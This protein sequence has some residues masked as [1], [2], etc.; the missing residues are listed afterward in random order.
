MSPEK[1]ARGT[2]VMSRART[3]K[4]P[5]YALGRRVFLLEWRSATYV[6]PDYCPHRGGPL[7]LGTRSEDPCAIRCPW[8]GMSNH[9]RPM[10]ERA[11]PAVQVGD[12]ISF[13]LTED[14]S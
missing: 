3:D 12:T 14:R 10:T 8:H 4:G 9:I 2:C 13:I 5:F 11:I 7:S 6:I 1:Q